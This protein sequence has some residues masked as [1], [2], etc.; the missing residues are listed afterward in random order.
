MEAKKILVTGSTG[1]LGRVIM[2]DWS[3]TN[4][5]TGLS[6][7]GG[8]GT[9][10]CDLSDLQKIGKV[11]SKNCFDLVIHTAAYSDVDGCERDPQAAWACN[12]LAVRNLATL[13]GQKKI[14]L[15]TVSTDYVFDGEKRSPYLESDPTRPVNIYG[16][17]KLEG[18][19]HTKNLAWVSAVVRTSWLFGAGNPRNFVNQILEVIKKG[20]EVSVL[21]DQKDCPTYVKDLAA[22]L[23]KIGS[24]LIILGKK[25]PANSVFETYHVCNGGITTR[26]DMT[27]KLKEFLGLKNVRVLRAK[28]SHIAERRAIRPAYAAMSTKRYQRTFKVSLRRW[29][30]A[31]KD[32]VLTSSSGAAS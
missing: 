6:R 25:N 29:Q 27:L 8:E 31:L 14:P 1:M 5:L 26:Y 13:C 7:R 12:A 15:L 11:F 20:P 30:E 9:V 4:D 28:A 16:M 23:E 17:T 18:E 22:A 10:A 21:A 3:F 19:V 2:S 32:Y 24:R